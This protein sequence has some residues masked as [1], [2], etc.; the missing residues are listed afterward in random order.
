MTNSITLSTCSVQDFYNIFLSLKCIT[1]IHGH[2]HKLLC[3][4]QND[5]SI[6]AKKVLYIYF[7]LL[8]DGNTRMPLD[9]D[10][11]LNK[12]INKFFSQLRLYQTDQT[13]WLANKEKTENDF[14][15]ILTE[16]IAELLHKYNHIIEDRKPGEKTLDERCTSDHQAIKYTTKPFVRVPDDI[17]H[18]QYL[19]ATRYF[20]A[21]CIIE[22]ASQNIF[23]EVTTV[24]AEERDAYQ[25][26]FEPLLIQPKD[27]TK[28]FRL[29]AHQ[30][31]AIIRGQ[32]ENLIITGGP[33]TGK[34][35]VICFLLWKLLAEHEDMLAWDIKLAAPS[36][37]AADRMRESLLKSLSF[38][39]DKNNDIYRKL[40]ALESYTI[41]RLLSYNPQRNIFNY[42]E[43]NRFPEK[44]IFIL[45]EASMI[46]IDLFAKFMQALPQK[47]YKL[48]ILGD[49][50]QLPSV[51]AGAVLGEMLATGHYAVQLV[52]SK[53][54]D[55]NSAI[56]RLSIA[57]KASKDTNTAPENVW[58]NMNEKPVFAPF[59]KIDF[60]KIDTG[61]IHY[62]TLPEDK[63]LAKNKLES[64]IQA[65]VKAFYIDTNYM[66]LAAEIFVSTDNTL[67]DGNGHSVS[68]DKL[69]QL[70]DTTLNARILS[71]ERRGLTGVQ[72][73]NELV[74]QKL[75][76]Q[77]TDTFYVGQLLMLTENQSS[78]KLYN[79]DCGIVLGEKDSGRLHLLLKKIK[80]QSHITE[81]PS[82]DPVDFVTYPLFMLPQNALE[83]A[84]AITIHKSQGSGYKN[85][86]MFLPQMEGHPLLNNQMI[87]TGVTRTEEISLT[88]VTRAEAF[89]AGC[90][91]QIIRDTGIHIA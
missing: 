13:A 23:R 82:D 12:W 41:H 81:T 26:Y 70:W 68:Q 60:S 43:D 65:W 24:T 63:S 6:N 4:M 2:V 37:K 75:S 32:R 35:T 79:G 44:T 36:G 78:L 74:S 73:L 33:G 20:D 5:M 89:M 18:I 67:V 10:K 83:S 57:I 64:L 91:T 45:D 51:E 40:H 61:S 30:L 86:L 69:K 46:D 49:P 34:T 56:G 31:D 42:R 38:F 84:F 66:K 90:K 22:K 21:K 7:S 80:T 77:M 19:Y 1:P 25:A 47:D 54:F 55:Q 52:D 72:T 9:A 88:I 39:K 16:G 28:K 48:Y 50:D 29:V 14:R 27:D 71:A 62:F 58:K 17:E 85:I 8:E 3:D 53:R 87:Y 15:T 11:A 59:N 76:R